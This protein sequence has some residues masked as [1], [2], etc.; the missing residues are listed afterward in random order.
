LAVE[1]DR[2]QVACLL[3][4]RRLESRQ[5][6]QIGRHD[7]GCY[8]EWARFDRQQWSHTSRAMSSEENQDGAPTVGERIAE[9]IRANE[10][11]PTKNLAPDEIKKLKAAAG[12]LEKLL[13]EAA[14]AETQE[15]KAAASKLEALLKSIGSSKDI[16]P[17]FRLR[18]K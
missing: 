15:L 4:V 6:L 5:Q 10:K 17:S 14:N 12:R 11:A 8:I 13:S 2:N 3:D 16:A 18:N 1:D 9:V 7:F